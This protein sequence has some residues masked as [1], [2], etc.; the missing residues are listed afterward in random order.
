MRSKQLQLISSIITILL[1]LGCTRKTEEFTSEP[2]SDYLPLQVGKYITYRLDSTVFTNFG[3]VTEVHSY[4]EKQIVDAQTTDASGRPAY[5]ILRYIRDVAGTQPWAPAGTYFIVPTNKTVEVI[6][7]NL[8][9]VKLA[10][11]VKK[12]FSWKG[13][14]FL[15]EKPFAGLYSFNNDYQMSDWDYTYDS[16]NLTTNLNGNTF[17]NVIKVVGINDNNVP[18]TVDVTNTNTAYIS[19][20]MTTVY[21]RGIATAQITITAAVP[22]LKPTLTIYNRANWPAVLD[23]ISIPVNGGK[24]FEYINSKWTYGYV[25]EGGGRKDTVY[26]DLP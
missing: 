5:R 4:Q 17:S 21:L 26:Y 23:S 7:N 8:R 9:F 16:V 19:D 25:A 6:E 1:L 11:P 24:P 20:S 18:D 15:P 22:K 13:N 2:L 14:E 12:D 10:L 3:T